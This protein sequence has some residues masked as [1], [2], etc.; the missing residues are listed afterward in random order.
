MSRIVFGFFFY[1]EGEI[2]RISYATEAKNGK[3]Y[4]K[5]TQLFSRDVC[6]RIDSLES[7]KIYRFD[8]SGRVVRARAHTL[9]HTYIVLCTDL[10][11]RERV[12][13]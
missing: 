3:E 11:E 5:K 1:S 8:F 4:K 10:Y 2:Y 12:C 13:V 9:T 6:I 7:K